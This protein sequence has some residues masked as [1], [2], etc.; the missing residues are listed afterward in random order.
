MEPGSPVLRVAL[1]GARGAGKTTVGRHLSALLGVPFADLDQE[2]SPDEPAGLL[3]A[4]VGLAAFRRQE[5]AALLRVLARSGP[6]VLATG[7][8]VV[9][10]PPAR[11]LLAEA[12][13][14]VWL[15]APAAVL[16]ARL[17]ADTAPRPPLAGADALE[18][19]EAVL[20]LREA[21]YAALAEATVDASREPAHVA[22]D[23][24]LALGL[25]QGR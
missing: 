14:C 4:R 22:R 6:W 24:A 9:E 17:E 13:R 5:L 2:T 16:R 3:L 21:Q 11:A 23:A 15:R 18:E 19:I 10:T 1:I 7:G 25:I 20:A 8:G 12:A